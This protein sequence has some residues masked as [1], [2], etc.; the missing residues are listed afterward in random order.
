MVTVFKVTIPFGCYFSWRN[1]TAENKI[2]SDTFFIP[3]HWCQQRICHWIH[4]TLASGY[5]T[6]VQGTSAGA[7]FLFVKCWRFLSEVKPG[8]SWLVVLYINPY[9]FF[10]V[11]HRSILH[12]HSTLNGVILLQEVIRLFTKLFLNLM[13]FFSIV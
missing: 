8:A 3:F 2:Y 6:S 13:L 5:Y 11:T 4:Q 7:L 1:E 9:I 10:S 12:C